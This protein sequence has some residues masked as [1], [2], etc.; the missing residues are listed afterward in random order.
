MESVVRVRGFPVSRRRPR[1][2]SSSHTAQCWPPQTSSNISQISKDW[3]TPSAPQPGANSGQR[4]R[5]ANSKCSLPWLVVRIT[6]AEC[7]EMSVV[8][9]TL[10][11]T[12]C[13]AT[14]GSHL[15][16]S[17]AKL[18]SRLPWV[19]WRPSGLWWLECVEWLLRSSYEAGRHSTDW[20]TAAILC[21]QIQPANIRPR[22]VSRVTEQNN[23]NNLQKQ[24]EIQQAATNIVSANLLCWASHSKW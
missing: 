6:W 17:R 15:T 9:T 13:P 19:P 11:S 10:I 16:S 12:S 4:A 20:S 5:F 3:N 18:V 24:V 21:D 22:E 2:Y 7:I 23:T 14:P 8:M 1:E